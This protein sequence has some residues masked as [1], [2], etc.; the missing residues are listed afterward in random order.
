MILGIIFLLVS[1]ELKLIETIA[2]YKFAQSLGQEQ[3]VAQDQ[4][5]GRIKLIEIFLFWEFA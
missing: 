4:F 1:I 3:D 2:Y 5:L